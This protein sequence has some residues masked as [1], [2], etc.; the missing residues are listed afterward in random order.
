MAPDTKILD[1]MNVPPAQHDL[2]WLKESLAAAIKLQ[3]DSLAGRTA[4]PWRLGPE[5]F[6]PDDSAVA[7]FWARNGS[8]LVYQASMPNLRFSRCSHSRRDGDFEV[9]SPSQQ[10]VE[11]DAPGGIRT[12]DALLRTEVFGGPP[13]QRVFVPITPA[14][15]GREA[16][17]SRHREFLYTARRSCAMTSHEP[18][19]FMR[20]RREPSPGPGDLQGWP[21]ASRCPPCRQSRR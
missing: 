10:R 11:E 19:I 5:P 14:Q 9:D 18:L 7:P 8:F 1:R 16:L 6:A 4:D 12:P 15:R 21:L 20:L 17:S 3:H 2:G 13:D